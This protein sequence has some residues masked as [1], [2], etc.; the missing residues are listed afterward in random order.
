MGDHHQYGLSDLQ[1]LMSG[2]TIFQGSPQVTEP[3]FG[4]LA[5]QGHHHHY[6]SIMAGEFMVPSG[7]VK[8]GHDHYC[9]YVNTAATT[10]TGTAAIVGT[11]SSSGGGGFLYGV[12]MENRGWMGNNGG[13]S[14]SRWPRQEALA[15]LEIRSKLDSRFKEANQKGPLWDEVSRIMAKEHGYQRSGR[16]CR[17]KFENLYKYYKKTKEGKSGR[18]DGKHY[19]FFRH[20]EALYGETS[21][22]ASTSETNLVPSSL[23][24]QPPVNTLINQKSKRSE[25]LSFS[26]TSEFE[27]SS[28]E[29]ND[30]DLSVIACMMN[31]SK[32]KL[33]KGRTESRSY[34]EEAKKR[35][36]AKVKNFVD[37][38]MRKLFET[39]E[40]WM[41][42]TLKSVEDRENERMLREEDWLKKEVARFNQEHELWAK[43]RQWIEARDAAL[44]ETLRKHTG[45]EPQLSLSI[46][47]VAVS[48]YRKNQETNSRKISNGDDNSNIRWTEPE[49]LSLTQLRTAMETK[50]Q[51]SG[52]Y[53]GE[54]LWEEISAYMYSLDYHRSPNECKEKWEAMN[55][56]FNITTECNKKHREDIRTDNSYVELETYNGQEIAKHK[57][58]ESSND[59][60]FD[61]PAGS[62]QVDMNEGDNVW[63]NCG[64]RL[65]N[66]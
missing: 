65:S 47:Q 11:S 29:N 25:I 63:E 3:V 37:S 62:F 44:M 34:S 23:R 40:T 39:Q 9:S 27:T 28:S 32:E 4:D 22:G 18:Q 53:S 58:P 51:E 20:F 7:L 41:E 15:L 48:S 60:Y 13:G 1:Q 26:Y 10:T 33:Q 56:Y 19:R 6:D 52:R 46:D 24:Y 59:S 64:L 55:V 5:P 57:R 66:K 50:F 31:R 49:I 21:N 35:W 8:L 43:E 12:D 61:P 14:S 30:D 54:G 2:T 36:K 45:K 42:R 17:E 38:R 16:K